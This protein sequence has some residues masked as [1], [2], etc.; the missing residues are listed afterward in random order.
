MDYPASGDTEASASMLL[1]AT[2]Q[3][4]QIGGNIANVIER[5]DGAVTAYS[6]NGKIYSVRIKSPFSGD[7]RGIKIGD[8]KSEVIRLLGKPNR[9]WPVHDGIDRWFYD[10]QSFM[11][12]DFNPE[13]DLV[14]FIYL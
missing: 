10:S 4:K 12:V 6:K 1:N 3:P 11:R 5:S 14:E 8:S 7:V 9:L 2:P 13:T